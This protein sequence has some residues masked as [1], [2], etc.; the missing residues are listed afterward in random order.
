MAK[1]RERIQD[2]LK[3]DE[4]LA[5]DDDEEFIDTPQTEPLRPCPWCG[6]QP[7]PAVVRGS[8][9]RWRQLAGC[10]TPGPEVRHDTLAEDQDKAELDSAGRARAEWN[11]R[12]DAA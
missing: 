10:C 6:G 11:R 7:H 12:W 1:N 3:P 4:D 8:T 9:F 2:L 5:V